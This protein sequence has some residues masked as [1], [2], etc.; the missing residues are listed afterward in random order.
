MTKIAEMV[1][2]EMGLSSVK[3]RYTGG[4]R[5]WKGDVPHFHLDISKIE[6]LGWKM[7]YT[8]DEAI[9]KAIREV[10]DSDFI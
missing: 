10:L 2:E 6:N 1:V 3:F 8:S 7:H 9:R 4:D 5:G